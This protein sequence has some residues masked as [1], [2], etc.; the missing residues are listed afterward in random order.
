[1]TY[2]FYSVLGTLEKEIYSVGFQLIF[3]GNSSNMILYYL[4]K[5]HFTSKNIFFF[6]L[7]LELK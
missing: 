6:F 1:M 5:S 3:K 4:L 2:I 7:I